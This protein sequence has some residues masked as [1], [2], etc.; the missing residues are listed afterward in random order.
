MSKYN[1]QRFIEAQEKDYDRAYREIESGR[2]K[3][4]WMWYIFPQLK[5]LGESYYSN[6]YGI[7]NLEEAREYLE[8]D[9]L[10]GNLIEISSLVLGLNTTDLRLVLGDI[11]YLKLRSC[12]TLFAQAD[13]DCEVFFR[14]IDKY[15]DGEPCARTLDLLSKMEN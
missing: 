12:M 11:D 5:G 1:I 10:G 2:K 7:A 4:H 8:D 13:P 14:V 3:S 15:Y 6:Y 9:Y